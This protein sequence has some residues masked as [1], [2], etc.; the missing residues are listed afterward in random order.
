[1]VDHSLS[2][3]AVTPASLDAELSGDLSGLARR[4]GVTVSEWPPIG[5]EWDRPAMEHFRSLLDTPTSD[6]RFGPFYV[7]ALGALVGTAGFFGPPDEAL[8]VEIGY[9][10]CTEARRRG[11]ATAT[12]VELCRR[13]AALGCSSVRAT[14]SP[15]N[16]ASVRA[17][18]R[19]GFAVVAPSN[20]TGDLLLLRRS[21]T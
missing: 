20:G 15:D 12:I 19:T 8:E 9:S 1:M 11:I 14:V 13:A 6:L 16:V 3:V 10:V 21:L 7:V 4:L 18:E 2:L 5:G 17:L